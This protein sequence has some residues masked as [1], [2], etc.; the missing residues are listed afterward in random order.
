MM[1]DDQAGETPDSDMISTLCPHLGRPCPAATRMLRA[2][3]RAGRAARRVT[4]DLD[5]TGTSQLD[6]CARACS[7]VF[8]LSPEGAAV[9]CGVSD[10]SEVAA[11]DRFASD[12]LA[13]DGPGSMPVEA[14][15]L[16]FALSP[17]SARV[18]AGAQARP[19]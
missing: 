19:C 1:T 14:A 5:M 6:G 8:R 3:D 15:P 17:L 9:F 2:L 12:F 18:V 4:P 7:A 16:A 11:L 10:E 13:C